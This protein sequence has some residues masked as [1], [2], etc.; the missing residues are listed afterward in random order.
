V[1]QKIKDFCESNNLIMNGGLDFHGYGNV[2]SLWNAMELPGWQ[3]LDPVSKEEAILNII[4]THDQSKLKVVLYTDRPYYAKKNL[5]F[6]PLLTFVNYFRTLNFYQVLSWI[7]WITC[8]SV[9]GRRLSNTMETKQFGPQRLAP[10]FGVL[11]ALFLLG[12]G[13]TYF[14]RI[15]DMEDFTEMYKEYSVLLFYVGS[16]MLVYSGFVTYRFFKQK[17]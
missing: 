15:K 14:F 12:L 11:G 17:E 2:C 16:G 3:N 8:F 5:F 1:Y 9:I 7:V 13:F 4:K 6:R 10:L